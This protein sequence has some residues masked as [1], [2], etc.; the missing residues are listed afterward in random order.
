MRSGHETVIRHEANMAQEEALEDEDLTEGL[1]KKSMSG[2]KIILFGAVGVVLVVVLVVV[3]MMFMG[4]DDPAE[5]EAEG[6]TTPEEITEEVVPEED[7]ALVYSDEIDL[8][9][10]LNTGGGRQALLT[11]Q[12]QLEFDRI[13]YRDEVALK[14]PPVRDQFLIFMRE[15]RPEDVEGTAGM[16]RLKE[17]LLMRVNQAVAPAKVKDIHFQKF[18][19]SER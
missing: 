7:K 13:S 19:V 4:G 16:L 3:L 18:Y 14:I 9:T 8:T 2:K 5:T 15:L 10:D 1:E 11:V 12:V 17:E 6:E